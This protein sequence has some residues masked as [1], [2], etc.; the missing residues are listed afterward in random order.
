VHTFKRDYVNV[1]ELGD[2][3]SMLL[4]LAA[5]MDGYN[6]LVPRSALG[7]RSRADHRAEVSEPRNS[8]PPSA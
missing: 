6:R 5:W 2:A 3:E 7:M 1:H 8:R 4:R